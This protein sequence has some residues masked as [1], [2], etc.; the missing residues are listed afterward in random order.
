[1]PKTELNISSV[2]QK[3][4][5]LGNITTGIRDK[6]AEL[7]VNDDLTLDIAC[8]N[9]LFFA[10]LNQ[11]GKNSM[12]FIGMDQSAELLREAKDI[13]RDN[14]VV[15]N[16]ELVRGDIFK[17]PF[18]KG[19]FKRVTC[20][21][22]ILNLPSIDKVEQL[23]I[24]MMNVCAD[25]GKIVIDVRNKSNPYIR[26]KYWLHRR[27]AQFPTIAYGLNDINEIFRRRGFRVIKRLPIGIPLP[28]AAS[29]YV[30][31]VEKMK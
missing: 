8:G 10:Y 6:A 15:D 7:C 23:L 4:A 5:F 14:G 13:F 21:N 9:G 25:N 22:T 19:L 16:A 17:L 26:L 3:K 18:K 24:E 1:M 11:T 2:A 12:K 27:R 31:E 28:I 20:L 30:L 29:A